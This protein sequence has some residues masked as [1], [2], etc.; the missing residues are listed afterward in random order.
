LPTFRVFKHGQN[1]QSDPPHNYVSRSRKQRLIARGA[2]E[3]RDGS[4]QLPLSLEPALKPPMP[5]RSY[6]D[7][8]SNGEWE[9][10]GSGVGDYRIP[11]LQFDAVR[12]Y[13]P[14]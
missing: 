4:I 3:L 9:V 12:G 5:R 13:V 7:G 10:H 1:P 2:K 8:V 11:V 6:S 14:R